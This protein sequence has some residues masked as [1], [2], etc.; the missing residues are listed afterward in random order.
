MKVIFFLGNIGEKYHHTRHNAAWL[1]A[2]KLA[3]EYGKKEFILNKQ[4][5]FLGQSV[6]VNSIPVLL[7]KP[8][9]LMNLSG[10][11]VQKTMQQYKLKPTDIIVAYDD[12][13]IPL[14]KIRISEDSYPKIHNGVNSIRQSLSTFTSIRI[15]IDNRNGDR[16]IPPDTYVLQNFHM[17]ELTTLISS[18]KVFID[19]KIIIQ[20][21]K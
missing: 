5:D 2:D 7:I 8:T 19:K 13:D 10:R 16:T 11:C 21:I 20:L 12:L 18:F 17:D 1:F 4:L 3:S 14:G 6:F 15:G 9:T